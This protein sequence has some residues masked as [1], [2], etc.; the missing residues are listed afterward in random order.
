MGTMTGTTKRKGR[1]D[2]GKLFNI[3]D[4][5]NAMMNLST[6][7]AAKWVRVANEEYERI[8]K[9]DPRETICIQR[10]TK[11]ANDYIL[12]TYGKGRDGKA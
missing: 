8:K 2:V 1:L 12:R 10:A 3:T 9:L 4:A 6:D 11:K 7:Q 5:H